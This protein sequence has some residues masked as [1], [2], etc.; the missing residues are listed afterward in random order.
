[1]IIFG[2]YFLSGC[3]D[4]YSFFWPEEESVTVV[5]QIRDLEAVQQASKLVAASR[6]KL[7]LVVALIIVI[8]CTTFIIDNLCKDLFVV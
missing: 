8:C 7:L 1:M 6:I 4:G 3:I 5:P 2:Q